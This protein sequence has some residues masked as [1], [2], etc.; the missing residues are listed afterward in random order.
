MSIPLII[1]NKKVQEVLIEEITTEI[2]KKSE[3]E[4]TVGGIDFS[5][6]SGLILEDVTLK[7]PYGNLV[8]D[9]NKFHLDVKW[10]KLFRKKLIINNIILDNPTFHLIT[11]NKGETNLQFL[12]D[13]FPKPEKKIEIPD[14]LLE[15]GTLQIINGD[16]QFDNT[17]RPYSKNL[18]STPHILD[19]RN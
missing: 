15:L 14:I 1:T 5:F 9:I 10:R 19:L 8:A 6:F 7:D 11:N 3:G 13:I 16:F 18:V 4:I 2:S 12:I 17:D